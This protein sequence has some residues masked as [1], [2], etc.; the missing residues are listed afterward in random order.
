MQ[1][2]LSEDVFRHDWVD[3]KDPFQMG[4]CS[5]TLGQDDN[6]KVVWLWE[7]PLGSCG[8]TV[9]TLNENGES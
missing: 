3:N 2:S 7:K 9:D 5:P 4:E 8:M 6:G 1:L